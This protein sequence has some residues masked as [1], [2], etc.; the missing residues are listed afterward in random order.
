[1]QAVTTIA[2]GADVPLLQESRGTTR[3][4]VELMDRLPGWLFL[5]SFI[6]EGTAG[7]VVVGVSPRL[8]RIYPVACFD[9][10]VQGRVGVLR[11]RGPDFPALDVANIHLVTDDGITAHESLRRL[12]AALLPTAYATTVLMGDFNIVTPSEGRLDVV[13]GA[14]RHARSGDAELFLDVFADYHE[15]I[16]E[17]YSRQQFRDGEPH[18]YARLDHVYTNSHVSGLAC[19]G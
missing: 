10:V 4:L 2:D 7:G 19:D 3:D 8:R 1:M 17:G 9:T 15:V 12:R 6:R 5:G 14:V 16:A 11:L 18:Q 13:S